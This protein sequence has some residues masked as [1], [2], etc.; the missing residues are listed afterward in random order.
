MTNPF[1]VIAARL[2]SIEQ[3]IRTTPGLQ[4]APPP[5]IIDV[6]EACKRL[7]ISRPTLLSWKAKGRIPYIQEDKVL[8]FEW[9][10]VVTSL[11]KRASTK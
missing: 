10:S 9:N 11:Q 3:A 8:R 5:E 2:D 7:N 1:E 6:D 4:V